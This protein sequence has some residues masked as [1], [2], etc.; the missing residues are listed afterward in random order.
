MIAQLV[1]RAVIRP[2]RALLACLGAVSA[3]LTP[4]AGL[5]RAEPAPRADRTSYVVETVALNL[6]RPWAVTILADGRKLVTERG[7][8]LRSI[9]ADGTVGDI[10]IRGLPP[11]DPKGVGGLLDVVP[12]PDFSQNALI[13]LTMSYV[14]PDGNGMSV[15][16]AK[17]VRTWLEDIQVVFRSVPS[18]VGSSGGGR[19]IFLADRTLLLTMGDRSSFREEAQNPANQLGKTLRIDRD[20]RAPADNPFVSRAGAAPEVYTIGHKNVLGVALDPAD[21]S[22]LFAE[23]GARGGDEINRARPGGNYGWPVVTGGID[24]SFAL[25]SPFSELP[26]F[27]KA[28]LEWTP[29]IAPGGL[30]VY[31]GDMF[32][33]WRG[34]LLV[35]ALKERT[36]RRVIRKDGGIVGQELLL[37]ELKE[38]VRDVKVARDGSIYV[39]TDGPMAKLLRLTAPRRL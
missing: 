21:G 9:A 22:L 5:V 20:G 10:S 19:L 16:R 26:G 32:P 37:A 1:L 15:V 23:H 29:S 38:R 17:L 7:G 24:Y 14:G 34:D 13:F 27:E 35:A 33:S 30:A 12:D 31:S 2:S 36:V 3:C 28:L 39:L 11:I 25:V 8:R 4:G 18:P 6:E